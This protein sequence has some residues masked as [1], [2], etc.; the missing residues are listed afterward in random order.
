MFHIN[1][2]S[3]GPCSRMGRPSG[4]LHLTVVG[5]PLNTAHKHEGV[6]D[7]IYDTEGDVTLT[8]FTPI[9]PE[10]SATLQMAATIMGILVRMRRVHQ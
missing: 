9:V 3:V 8:N 1:P 6:F 4:V 7:V 2:S 5:C 10:P